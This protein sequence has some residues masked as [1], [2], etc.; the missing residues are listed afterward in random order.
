MSEPI[1]EAANKVVVQPRV[2]LRYRKAY[3]ATVPWI[4]QL[5]KRDGTHSCRARAYQGHQCV[6]KAAWWLNAVDQS[7][8]GYYCWTHACNQIMDFRA[9]Y[10][11][12]E[13]WAKANPPYW[14]RNE[15]TP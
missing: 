6:V 14:M 4:R 12:F 7:Y 1:R 9:E 2:P 11:R 13:A 8:S 3:M 15:G 10:T 5:D